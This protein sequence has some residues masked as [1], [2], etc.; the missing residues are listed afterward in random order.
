MA[1]ERALASRP[2]TAEAVE[3]GTGHRLATAAP[4]QVEGEAVG[5]VADPLQEPGGLGVARDRHGLGAAGDV[6]LLEP[7][8]EGD[9][10]RPTLD[11]RRQRLGADAELALA[12][13]D[14]DQA[15]E[16]GEA[17]VE[18]GV[19]R[20]ALALGDVA[21]EAPGQHLLHRSEVVGAGLLRAPADVET[22]VVGL[23]RRAALEDDHRGNGV[24]SSQI[25]DVVALDPDRGLVQFE[26]LRQL[27]EGLGPLTPGALPAQALLGE[28]EL[29]VALGELAQAA[30]VAALGGPDLHRG[31]A[32]PADCEGEQLGAVRELRAD[33]DQRRH[34]RRRLVVL[35][36]ELLGDLG[37]VALALVVE[38]EALA[39]G[40]DA[41]AD[42]EDLRVGV[43]PLDRYPDQVSGAHL[44]TRDALALHQRLDG[45]EPVAE[46]RG[47]LELLGLGG[48]V[49]LLLEVALDLAI[50]AGEEA[51]DG[52]D[53]APVLV[54][55]DVADAWRPTPLDVVVEAGNSRPSAGLGTV[56]GPVLEELAEQLERL[57]DPA[58]V[59]VGTEVG[60][61]GTVALTGEVDARELLVEADPDVG[62]GLVVAQLHVE[63][64]A[65]TLDELLLGDQRLG[66]GVGDEE[67]DRLDLVREAP[68]GGAAGEM[69]GD[70]FADRL[71]L[72]DVDHPL[73]AVHEDVDARGVGQ[74]LPLLR[75]P[76]L[77]PLPR[78]LR[79][80]TNCR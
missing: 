80:G 7:L 38:V 49:H 56:A 3:N 25:G 53:V 16:A 13:V 23:L 67:V 37:D 69:R 44:L 42:L 9:D 65:V 45:G 54:G 71:R 4:M 46:E 11:Q 74:L 1:Q 26:R 31:P 64:R 19:V 5:L 20:R 50:A 2:D 10:G 73:V 75:D 28:G 62:V 12:A 72:A 34:R 27:I 35:R 24:L 47:P 30:L 61:V 52:V 33:D 8:G 6:D 22:A 58:R 68:Q 18:L 76:L 15:R 77:A 55:I 79:H 66:L 32:T 43:G 36:D 17:L 51:P 29:G 63:H 78:V 40:E 60:A 14:H 59:R 70:P 21:V 57:P 48:L 39:L 41:V